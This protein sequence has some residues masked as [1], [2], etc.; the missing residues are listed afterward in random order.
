MQYRTMV[1]TSF[2]M[3]VIAVSRGVAQEK[4]VTEEDINDVPLAFEKSD[5][6]L[7][8]SGGV[9]FWSGH[10]TYAI[11]GAV[12]L[13]DGSTE[14][15]WFPISELEF[16]LDTILIGID[17]E[18]R[19][20]PR[21]EL[22]LGVSFS[23]AGDA[24][25]MKDSDWIQ[26]PG[27]LDIYSESDAELDMWVVEANARYHLLDIG[28]ISMAV[29]VGYIYEFFDYEISN[30]DQTYPS[31]A[32]W[33]HEYY[34]DLA[35]LYEATFHIPYVEIS[36]GMN[37]SERLSLE[38]RVGY[39]PFVYVEDEDNHLLR[40]KIAE[41]ETDGDAV[42]VSIAGRYELG[43]A[44]F[45]SAGFDYRLI[46]T[47]GEQTQYQSGGLLATIDNTIESEQFS[48]NVSVG[49]IF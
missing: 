19:M 40:D 22:S 12:V 8:V 42:L 49:R 35:L 38:G 46:E 26:A 7:D 25:T 6:N 36:A 47:D 24:G 16:P 21:V 2:I 3:A 29:G 37:L 20:T 34:S 18:Y 27:S 4:A 10:A 39:A 13:S 23:I 30:V 28:E 41:S 44:W 9:E 1:A 5:G 32:P 15:T 43:N 48:L 33:Y 45:A 14:Q 31:T 11:G 17:A